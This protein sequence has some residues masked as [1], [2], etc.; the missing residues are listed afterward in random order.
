MRVWPARR[1]TGKQVEVRIRH[2]L[3]ALRPLLNIE[4][5]R[6]ELVSFEP[7]TG[8]ATLRFAGDCPDCDMSTAMLR[9]GV[10]AHLRMQIPEITAV[11]AQ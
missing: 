6:V 11:R 1:R 10:E 5:G 8:V 9:D 3:D 2:A 7:N 4:S